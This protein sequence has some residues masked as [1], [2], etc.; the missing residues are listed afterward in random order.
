MI[1]F[2]TF[3]VD[4][5]LILL[6]EKEIGTI[7]TSRIQAFNR[8]HQLMTQNKYNV[9]FRQFNCLCFIHIFFLSAWCG[10]SLK[11]KQP[12]VTADGKPYK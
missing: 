3:F 1:I 12:G 5:L 10:R 11:V 2:N 7:K 4:C 8:L 9:D 6:G